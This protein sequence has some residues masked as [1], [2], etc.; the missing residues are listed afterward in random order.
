MKS[1]EGSI[2]SRISSWLRKGSNQHADASQE[3][4]RLRS[5][6]ARLSLELET[7]LSSYDERTR[8][9]ASRL[10]ST[11]TPLSDSELQRVYEEQLSLWNIVRR[12]QAGERSIPE[13]EQEY[14]DWNERNGD[15]LPLVHP[16][17]PKIR[18]ELIASEL[19]SRG[20]DIL[21]RTS[22]DSY[23]GSAKDADPF[24]DLHLDDEL[25]D[26]EPPVESN[27]DSLNQIRSI[28]IQPEMRETL[29]DQI[30]ACGHQ[31][32]KHSSCAESSS[33]DL[34]ELYS[35]LRHHH[36]H[37]RRLDRRTGV[38]RYRVVLH[39]P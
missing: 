37:L 6:Q 17:H 31:I 29:M 18:L 10:V 13:L 22:P 3:L 27:D 19:R 15:A 9:L 5:E 30:R 32:R 28:A 7:V 12:L 26:I 39:Q 20:R 4:E 1:D 21:A 23:E 25:V 38:R 16:D 36:A 35:E 2:F 34:A 33:Q 8:S 11:E 14:V 24:A